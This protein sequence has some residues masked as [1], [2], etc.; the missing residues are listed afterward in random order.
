PIRSIVGSSLSS[1]L[2]GTTANPLM[3]SL[4]SKTSMRSTARACAVNCALSGST[5]KLARSAATAHGRPSKLERVFL[6]NKKALCSLQD[7]HHSWKVP[8]RVAFAI[9]AYG[10]CYLYVSFYLSNLIQFSSL[11]LYSMQSYSSMNSIEPTKVILEKDRQIY[12]SVIV[13]EI[14]QT[15]KKYADNIMHILE[16]VSARLTQLES[17]TCHLE[18]SMDDLKDSVGNNNGSIDGKMRQLENIL[19]KKLG[20]IR[21]ST[22][23]KRKGL[24][25]INCWRAV[26]K[27]TNT[28]P[29]NK[30]QAGNSEGL[31]AA[32]KATGT[33]G[34][35]TDTGSEYSARRFQQQVASVPQQYVQQLPPV[36]P[37]APPPLTPPSVPPPPVPQPNPPAPVQV[38]SQFNQLP[39]T[40][41]LQS[42]PPVL[43]CQQYQPAPIAP[44]PTP[45]LPPHQNPPLAAENPP[46]LPPRM[47]HHPEEPAYIPSQSYPPNL[48]QAPSHPPSGAPSS[49]PYYEAPSHMYEPPPGRSSSGY[50]ST[51]GPQSGT[52]EPYPPYSAPPAQYG[53]SSPLKV[54]QLSSSMESGGGSGYPQLPTAHV[55]PHALPASSPG[56]PGSSGTGNRVPIND[57]V[58]TVTNM[59]FLRDHL[60]AT[61]RKL[62]ENGQSVD[63]NVV[64]D[65]LMNDGDVQPPRNWFGQ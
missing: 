14:D 17:R 10:D 33:E 48:R 2:D 30:G 44:Y 37:Q 1:G 4:D 41:Q 38:P 52:N 18:N 56:S 63:L 50:S 57:V 59:G 31:I 24:E 32:C 29:G 42:N 60:R 62:P 13:S 20:M 51:Y 65:K 39:L 45:S 23:E 36:L 19:R 7:S 54:P 5:S 55:L 8:H 25:A 12:D 35:C 61:V 26:K 28:C 34:R 22:G 43:P 49:Q 40:Q 47:G 64:L 3:S 15:M 21:G 27:S 16:G 58:D 11:L 6:A 9:K 46:P 53:S